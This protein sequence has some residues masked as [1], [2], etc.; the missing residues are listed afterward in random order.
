MLSLSP[1]L[2]LLPSLLSPAPHAS[3][4]HLLNSFNFP[5]HPQ[6]DKE[7]LRQQLPELSAQS[8][9]VLELS[10]ALLKRCTEAGLT[11]H[12]VCLHKLRESDEESMQG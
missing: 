2:L 1:L 6:A 8:L 3:L 9:R 4:T 12:Q 7:M 10:T 5:I 11:L